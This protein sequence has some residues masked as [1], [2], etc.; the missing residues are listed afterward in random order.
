MKRAA[1]MRAC[2]LAF[3]QVSRWKTQS[4]EIRRRITR[5]SSTCDCTSGSE[6]FDGIVGH[7][8]QRR[9]LAL[10]LARP[11]RGRS[12][13]SRLDARTSATADTLN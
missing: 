11:L 12:D 10:D 8:S 3:D 9:D 13:H 7:K 5:S 6:L 1:K 2:K 4:S